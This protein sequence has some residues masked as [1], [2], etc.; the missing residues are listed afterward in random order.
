M[1]LGPYGCRGDLRAESNKWSKMRY[2]IQRGSQEY[3]PYS[4]ADIQG[5]LK[6]GALQPTD[7]SRTDSMPNW[8]PLE[9]LVRE[10][11]LG[12]VPPM[13]PPPPAGLSQE[14]TAIP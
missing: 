3:G 5:F 10:S 14:A 11:E 13:P 7:A 8:V 4:L 1:P 9:R 2:F 6:Q 12:Q